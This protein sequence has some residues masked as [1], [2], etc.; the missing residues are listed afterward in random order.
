[1]AKHEFTTGVTPKGSLLF[2]HI[3]EPETYEGKDVGFTV[4]IKFDQKETDA[5]IAVIDK[6]LEKAKHSI[7]LKPGQKWSAEPFLGYRED[8]D[9]D[10]IFKFKANSHYTTKSGETHKVTIPVFDAHGK[11]IKDP[12]SIGNG[13]IAKVAY[14]LVPYWI[15]KVVN[16]IKLRLD[17]VQIIDLKEYGEKDAKGYGFGEEE[18]F[19][20]PE[21]EDDSPF[22][23]SSEEDTD[24][25]GEF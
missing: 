21:E 7:K 18:G 11:P 2:P 3:Y 23:D 1:M 5:L 14:T 9:G 8:K 12:L 16:G 10:I 17:A 13:T 15:S 25:D 22:V 24:E 19:S 20:A 6:E 4:N